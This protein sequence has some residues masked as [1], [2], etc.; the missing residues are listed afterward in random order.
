[1]HELP[2]LSKPEGQ[3]LENKAAYI[4]NSRTGSRDPK[5]RL[6]VLKTIAAFLNTEGGELRIGVDNSGQPSGIDAELHELFDRDHLDQFE[7]LLQEAIVKCLFPLPVGKVTM[8]FVNPSGGWVCRIFVKPAAGVTYLREK[9]QSGEQTHTIYVR[10]GNRTT[11]LS[12]S[13][14]DRFVVE[15]LSGKWPL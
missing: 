2:D 4:W 3:T 7:L 6:G 14:R 8:Q 9:S 13:Q 15:R 1:M 12:D 5:L 11:A 10:T